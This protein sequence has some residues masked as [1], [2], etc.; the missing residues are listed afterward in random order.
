LVTDALI[1]GGQTID[2]Q[3]ATDGG[4]FVD[5]GIVS[6]GP[7]ASVAFPTGTVAK[8]ISI[9]LIFSTTDPSKTPQLWAISVRVS[10]NTALYRLVEFEGVMTSGGLFGTGA[11]D[12][13]NAHDAIVQLWND[14]SAGL[15]VPFFD[16]WGDSYMARIMDFSEQ[17]STMEPDRTPETTITAVLLLVSGPAANSALVLY[18][19]ATALY[20]IP[21]SVY[22]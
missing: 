6:S 20:D 11:G 12:M 7:G 22:S 10:L 5:L 1:P 17:Q 4:A 9:R 16:R 14:V 8:R 19:T 18:D 3:M 21:S 15:P 2:V 13:T